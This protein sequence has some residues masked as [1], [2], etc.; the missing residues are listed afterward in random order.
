MKYATGECLEVEYNFT[1]LITSVKQLKFAFNCY[2][3]L[4]NS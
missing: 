3:K 4:R 2:C 1:I